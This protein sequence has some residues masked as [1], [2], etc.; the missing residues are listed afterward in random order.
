MAPVPTAAGVAATDAEVLKQSTR[1]VAQKRMALISCVG[2]AIGNASLLT[3]CL[4][5]QP[6]LAC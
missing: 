3:V 4:G 1:L 5:T 6:I 2:C